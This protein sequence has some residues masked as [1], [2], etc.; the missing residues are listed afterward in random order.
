MM[1]PEE[2]EEE[3]TQRCN[4]ALLLSSRNTLSTMKLP[5]T[6]HQQIMTGF[7]FMGDHNSLRKDPTKNTAFYLDQ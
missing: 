1:K 5:M 4:T 7:T 2:D 6:F 3:E